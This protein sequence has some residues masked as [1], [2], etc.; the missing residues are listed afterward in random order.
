MAGILYA[1]EVSGED[2]D[3]GIVVEMTCKNV[4]KTYDRQESLRAL[5]A[6]LHPYIRTRTHLP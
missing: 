4:C 1:K 5:F 6:S 3:E 2:R